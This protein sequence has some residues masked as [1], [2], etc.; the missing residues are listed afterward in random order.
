[1]LLA[2]GN[3]FSVLGKGAATDVRVHTLLNFVTFRFLQ[4]E[5]SLIDLAALML[6]RVSPTDPS[7]DKLMHSLTTCS[8]ASAAVCYSLC[9]LIG[10]CGTINISD[11]Q[12]RQVCFQKS[13]YCVIAA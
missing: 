11:S 4:F 13:V 5:S 7:F 10:A 8:T 6:A 1:M 2:I 9:S 3:A 12:V